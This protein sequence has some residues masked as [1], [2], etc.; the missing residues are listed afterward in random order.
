MCHESLPVVLEPLRCVQRHR[1]LDHSIYGRMMKKT[2]HKNLANSIVVIRVLLVFW[3]IALLSAYDPWS[4]GFGLVLMMLSALLDWVDGYVANT[5]KISS[6]VGGLLDTMGDRITENL[7]FIFFAYKG[8]IP[9]YVPLF[10]IPRSFVADFIRTLSFSSGLST[11][12][13]NTSAWG[14]MLVASP[15]SR[16][17]YL[18]MKISIFL[19][20]GLLLV[21]QSMNVDMRSVWI[22]GLQDGIVGCAALTVIFSLLR[23]ICLVY[24]S[25]SILKREFLA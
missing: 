6:R 7:L 4:R 2:V 18:A 9:L 25:R 20:G 24:D 19:A 13:V 10:Y 22:R 5:L 12:E 3:A 15:W 14:Q 21:L 16:V 1:R 8:I 11:F 17:V 23:F